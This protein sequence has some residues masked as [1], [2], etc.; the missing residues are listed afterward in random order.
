MCASIWGA[1][2][3]IPCER[4]PA[5]HLA[6]QLQLELDVDR[7]VAAALQVAGRGRVLLR[8]LRARQCVQRHDPGADRGLEALAEERPERHVLVRL[9]VAR[10]P[11]VDDDR[12]EDDVLEAVDGDARPDGRRGPDDEAE[13]HLDVQLPARAELRPWQP[14]AARPAHRGAAD[15]DRAGAPVVADGEVLPVRQQRLAVGRN[16]RPR[17][18]ACCSLA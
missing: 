6:V 14:Q 2:Q 13:L 12:A 1:V 10:A 9:Q 17:L 18:V 5:Q 11:V 8:C 4:R 7:P 3:Y 16:I 15:G